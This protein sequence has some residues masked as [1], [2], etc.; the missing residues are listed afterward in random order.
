M[1]DFLKYLLLEE[2]FADEEDELLLELLKNEEPDNIFKTRK[3]EGAYEVL[4][5]RHLS[6]NKAKFREYFRLTPAL[7]NEVLNY[8][9]NDIETKPCNRHIKPITPEEKLSITLR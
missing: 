9:R 4:I 5:K 3:S 8:I 1:E 7:F 6:K 2:E